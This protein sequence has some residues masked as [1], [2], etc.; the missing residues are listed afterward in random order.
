MIRRT[1]DPSLLSELDSELGIVEDGYDYDEDSYDYDEDSYDED[2]RDEVSTD[3]NFVSTLIEE[4][5]QL[6]KAMRNDKR[7]ERLLS[8]YRKPIAMVSWFFMAISSICGLFGLW[9]LCKL[10]SDILSFFSIIIECLSF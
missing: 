7:R 3:N 2:I 5:S 1:I 6:K 4:H 10:S 8:A 9:F